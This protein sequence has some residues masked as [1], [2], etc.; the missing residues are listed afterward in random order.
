MHLP[1]NFASNKLLKEFFNP[2]SV[3]D[4]KALYKQDQ[5]WQN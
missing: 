2:S 4:H 3:Q 1:I 5:V